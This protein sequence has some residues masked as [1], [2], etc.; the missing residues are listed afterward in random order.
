MSEKDIKR[1]EAYLDGYVDGR[2]GR[3]Y[4][5]DYGKVIADT[6]DAVERAYH[7]GYTAGEYDR[8]AAKERD[9]DEMPQLPEHSDSSYPI[10]IPGRG[11][12]ADLKAGR[13][14]SW[15]VKPTLLG[16]RRRLTAYSWSCRQ[17]MSRSPLCCTPRL[18]R[19]MPL[20]RAW[21]ASLGRIPAA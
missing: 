15:A 13:S 5:R 21:W 16:R 12:R 9:D 7:T 2:A 4:A 1:R 17:G 3:S 14:W 18:Q 10:R 8:Q 11:S 20:S 6:M 19:G